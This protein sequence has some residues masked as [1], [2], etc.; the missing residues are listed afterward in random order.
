M[1][2]LRNSIALQAL[3]KSG[4]GSKAGL[5]DAIPPGSHCGMACHPAS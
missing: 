3:L 4:V 2:Q 5:I 1:A